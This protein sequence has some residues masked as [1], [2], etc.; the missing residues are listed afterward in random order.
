MFVRQGWK[1]RDGIVVV[2]A[3]EDLVLHGGAVVHLGVEVPREVTVEHPAS[4][5]ASC[6]RAL[7]LSIPR[8]CMP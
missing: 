3:S 2:S 5:T 6:F 1:A 8:E 7:G 4:A